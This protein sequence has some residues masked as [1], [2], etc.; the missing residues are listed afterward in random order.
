MLRDPATPD[1]HRGTILIIVHQQTSTPGRVGLALEKRGFALDIRRPRFGDPLPERM[2]GFAGAAIFGG[3]MSANDEDDYL[4]R[5][6]DWL[7]VPLRDNTPLL[8]ICL[9]AQLLARQLGAEVA[10]HPD[11]LTEIGYYDIHPTEAGRELARWPARVYQWHRE[12][13]T[14]PKDATL[15]ASGEHFREEAFRYGD[16][17]YGIQFH[18]EVTLAM[19]HRWTVTAAERLKLKGAQPR[20]R[21]FEGHAR[22]D[23]GMEIWLDQFLDRWTG[24]A[25]QHPAQACGF[26]AN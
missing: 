13:F 26:T 22:Y 11:G 5:E 8:G 20:D 4:A 21:H 14:L 1:T 15:L 17:A 3:P 25:A 10:P 23:A 6:I 16:A 2:D 18:P 19:M 9:G 7:A 24:T 12:G